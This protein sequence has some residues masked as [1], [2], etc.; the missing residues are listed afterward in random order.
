MPHSSGG[1]SHSGGSHG[2]HSSSRGGSSNSS[3]VSN[4]Y[5]PG[6]KRYMYYDDNHEVH[7]QYSNYDLSGPSKLRLLLLIIYIPFIIAI[8]SG[9]IGCIFIPRRLNNP[10]S[11]IV[12][13]D[14]IGVIQDEEKL[15]ATL[16]D[17]Y[18]KTGV[19]PAVRTIYNED[20]EGYY[21]TLE[22]YAYKAYVEQF[23][24]EMHWVIVYSQPRNMNPEFPDWYW[25]GMIGDDTGKSISDKLC[26]EFTDTMHANLYRYPV[27]TA[28]ATT[29]N[30]TLSLRKFSVSWAGLGMNLFMALFIGI[31]MFFMVFVDKKE[32]H[33]G[34]VV[35]EEEV[36]KIRCA[37]C[38]GTYASTENACPH[39]AGIN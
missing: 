17:F 23:T 25:E 26:E 32:Y 9:L 28:I 19:T 33:K 8:I 39:C 6:A 3:R 16:S 34:A 7:F 12:I 35:I 22:D 5:F 30:E 11:E 37:Y 20:W 10:N 21:T 2:G 13:D 18:E 24:D 27:E 29:F 36:E 4:T 1:G 38:G 31:H 15:K 14:R